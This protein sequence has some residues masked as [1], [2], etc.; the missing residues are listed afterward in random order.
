KKF[1]D[2]S[3]MPDF[4]LDDYV[5]RYNTDN[6]YTEHENE[7]IHEYRDNAYFRVN[8][9]IRDNEVLDDEEKSIVKGVDSSINKSE[10]KNDIVL[11]R[12]IGS[13]NNLMFIN[14]LNSLQP[15]DVYEEQGYS[16]TTILQG[17]SEKFS[18]LYS[19]KNNIT[20]KIYASKGQN[21]LCMQNL[22][23][24]DDIEMYKDEYEFLLPRNQK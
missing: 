9:K 14:Y 17:A 4:M 16:S 1:L 21:A 11:Y 5:S 10:L 15:G 23:S 2:L 18:N 6:N 13:K 7:S 3:L 22:G 20:L 12:G 19:S 24:V 8:K